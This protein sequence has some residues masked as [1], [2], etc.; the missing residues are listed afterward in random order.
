[1]QD[2][3][4]QPDGA[5]EAALWEDI[6]AEAFF[7]LTISATKKQHF[8]DRSDRMERD[9]VL[10][11][12]LESF[13]L[14]QKISCGKNPIDITFSEYIAAAERD[15]GANGQDGATTRNQLIRVWQHAFRKLRQA[16]LLFL[17]DDEADRHI[18]LSFEAVLRPALLKLLRGALLHRFE[19]VAIPHTDCS[20]DAN[21][22]D[23]SQGLSIAEI[24]DVLLTQERF[25]CISLE[26]VETGLEHL[27]ASQQ[28][29]Q[30]RDTQQFF[31]K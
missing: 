23:H 7:S 5:T 20:V 30:R 3:A 24:A 6:A 11:E 18:L 8:L 13:L 2:G 15:A 9:R 27:L 14:R 25:K 17:E 26:W 28:V 10:L 29:G 4:T 1:M 19:Y 22:L 16:G 31:I 21:C 12:T